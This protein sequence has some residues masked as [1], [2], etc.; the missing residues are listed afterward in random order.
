MEIKEINNLAELLDNSTQLFLDNI[1]LSMEDKVITY[2][3]LNDFSEKVAS[4]LQTNRIKK[5]DNIAIISENRPEWGIAFFGITKVGA[6][7]VCMDPFLKEKEIEF[8]LNDSESAYVFASETFVQTLKNISDSLPSLRGVIDLSKTCELQGNSF[9]SPKIDPDDIAI[10]IYTSGT[11]GSQKGVMLSHRNI[12][13]DILGAFERVPYTPKTNFLSLLPLSH[14]FGITA[15]FLGPLYNGGRM[16]YSPSL[17]GYEILDTMQ[18][19]KTNIMVVAPLMLRIFY[20][21]MSEKIAQLSKIAKGLFKLNFSISKLFRKIGLNCGKILFSKIHNTFG[22]E[23]QYF[24]CGGASLDHEIEEY[25]Y[26]LGLSILSGYGLTETSPI[27]SVNTLKERKIGSVGKPLPQVEVKVIEKGEIIVKGPN[28]MK[29]YYKNESATDKL[30]KSGWFHT[31]DI[32]EIDKDGFLYI[33]GREKNVIVTS[34]GL[35]IFPEEI[36]ARLLKSPYIKEVCVLGRK[37][38]RGEQPHAVIYPSYE[39]LRGVRKREKTS[40]IKKELEE[41][42]KD[43]AL[44]KKVSSFEI[45]D[46]ELPKTSTRKIKR[47]LLADII[48]KQKLGE[49]EVKETEEM[50]LFASRI[51]SI[52]AKTADV[53]ETSIGWESNFAADLG[54][55]S[56]MKIELLCELDKELGVYIPEEYSYQIEIFR[57]LVSTTQKYSEAPGV[58]HA[59]LLFSGTKGDV[60]DIIKEN[61]LFKMTRF[62]TSIIL[63]HIAKFYFNLKIKHRDRVPKKGSFIIAANHTSLLDFPLIYISLPPHTMK[64]MTAP[65]AKDY[66]FKNPFISLIIQAAFAAFPLERYGNFFEGLKVCAKVIKSGKPLVLFPEGTR[67]VKGKLQSFKPGIGLLAFELDVS[68][69]PVYIKGAYK[70]LPKGGSFPNPQPVKILFG[71]PIIP[72][73]YKK[74]KDKIPNYKI[75]QKIVEEIRKRIVVLMK[76]K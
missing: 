6:T 51:R 24:I 28:V 4:Y 74:F 66:F 34:A 50:D 8:I 71:N 10:L 75:Y 44:Y 12:L 60:S 16:A 57:D 61:L 35:K 37:A 1:A 9:S 72:Q 29:G 36:E 76:E 38:E 52:V 30:L 13:S 53:P 2:K 63:F 15:G 49:V 59:D 54:I 17:K 3:E 55:D 39:L 42:Q 5:G 26:T 20:D 14:M 41:Y 46:K 64:D 18:R 22:G 62:F 32:G 23:L 48:A 45:W 31:G 70:A 25:F 19:T 69:L 27:V 58:A 11:M 56:L 67:S 68:I 73:D 65:A 43:V 40:K 33:K 47:K 21:N 7:A